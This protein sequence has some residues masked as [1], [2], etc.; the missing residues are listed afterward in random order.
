M[1]PDV[2]AKADVKFGYDLTIGG[3]HVPG[4]GTSAAAPLWASLA[5]LLNEE[6]RAPVGHITPLLY[7]QRMPRR[8]RGGWSFRRSVGAEGRLGN[9]ARDCVAG[10][11][12][13][14]AGS[15]GID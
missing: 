1:V 9:A 12:A 6:L 7:D 15:S 4:C 5:A 2:A 3:V 11:A 14:E 8:G 10:G 13:S